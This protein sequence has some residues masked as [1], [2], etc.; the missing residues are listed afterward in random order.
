MFGLLFVQQT[1]KEGGVQADQSR[2]PWATLLGTLTF[3]VHLVTNVQRHSG[4]RFFSKRQ[5]NVYSVPCDA[6]NS[7]KVEKRKLSGLLCH[8][9]TANASVLVY[10]F[11]VTF[12][13]E[14]PL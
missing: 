2:P 4:N 1:P 10:F 7:G 6:L 11:L 12:Q 3:T 5:G 8:L 9:K 13:C 14:S